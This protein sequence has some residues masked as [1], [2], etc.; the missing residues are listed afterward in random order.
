MFKTKEYSGRG[1]NKKFRKIISV[2]EIGYLWA[3]K[4]HKI[5]KIYCAIIQ[6]KVDYLTFLAM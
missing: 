1:V 4:I 2:E 5:S 3:Y 6:L